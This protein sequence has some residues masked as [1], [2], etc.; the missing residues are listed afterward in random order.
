MGSPIPSSPIT[1]P[2]GAPF[3]K[4]S[5]G[6]KQSGEKET[7]EKS[8]VSQTASKVAGQAKALTNEETDLATTLI[9]HSKDFNKSNVSPELRKVLDKTKIEEMV[10]SVKDN[11]LVC[12]KKNDPAS[13]IDI[14]DATAREMAELERNWENFRVFDWS[15]LKAERP[16][17][18]IIKMLGLEIDTNGAITGREG[19]RGKFL[20][21]STVKNNDT[22][23][24]LCYCS[25]KDGVYREE[26]IMRKAVNKDKTE[27]LST[28]TF[29]VPDVSWTDSGSQS[30]G[31]YIQRHP[32]LIIDREAVPF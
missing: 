3:S 12:H 29:P 5:S 9:H 13:K 20:I 10:V 22:L 32:D 19:D 18:T 25:A 31:E 4:I 17:E 28:V 16:R 27:I 2:G 14:S 23:Y 8:A 21:Y 7:D 11:H 15:D 24:T 6:D 1:P 26:E 30:L